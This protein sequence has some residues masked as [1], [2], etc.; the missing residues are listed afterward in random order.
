MQGA[1]KEIGGYSTHKKEG[2]EIRRVKVVRGNSNLSG[3]AAKSL[4]DVLNKQKDKARI[5]SSAS[6]NKAMDQSPLPPAG[7]RSKVLYTATKNNN[8]IRII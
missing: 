2:S 3:S 1:I 6:I 7:K 4:H 8:H 5:P